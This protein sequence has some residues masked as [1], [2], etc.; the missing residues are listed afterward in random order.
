M[1]AKIIRFGLMAVI[2]GIFLLAGVM[3]IYDPQGFALAIMEYQL[4]PWWGIVVLAV[5]MPWLELLSALALF[6]PGWRRA[7]LITLILLLVVFSLALVIVLLRGIDIRCGCFG[8]GFLDVS[9]PVALLRNLI[10]LAGAGYLLKLDK[11]NR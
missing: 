8:I 5:Y 2:A 7:S 11:F 1:A 10:L 3:K 9:A 4:I 6:I